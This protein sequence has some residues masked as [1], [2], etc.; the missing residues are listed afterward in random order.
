[1]TVT[2]PLQRAARQSASRRAGR[3]GRETRAGRGEGSTASVRR[4][5]RT[6]SFVAAADKAVTGGRKGSGRS[7]RWLMRKRMADAAAGRR[8]AADKRN[9]R[10]PASRGRRA[11]R[12]RGGERGAGTAQ[13]PLPDFEAE[14]R[15]DEIAV[16]AA[17]SAI[18]AE[19]SK[20]ADRESHRD[21]ART[22]AA[23]QSA[24]R[25][26]MN[27]HP[28]RV[29]DH[30]SLDRGRQPLRAAQNSVDS[31]LPQFMTPSQTSNPI[32]GG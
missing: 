17:I 23:A 18:L 9:A 12:G 15:E 29:T 24:A 2:T 32:C 26:V 10:R 13:G 30:F 22:F 5:E 19:A 11:G 3:G 16:E 21:R 31:L 1:M 20:K 25:V 14:L 27:D 6:R 28:P 4:F 8:G 7:S